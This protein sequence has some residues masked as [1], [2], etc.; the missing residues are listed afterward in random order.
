MDSPRDVLLTIIEAIDLV[1]LVTLL[2][3]Q[4]VR[5]TLRS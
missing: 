4:N 1:F 5:A 3:L 2:F